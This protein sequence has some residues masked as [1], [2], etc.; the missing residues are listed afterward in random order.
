MY[1]PQAAA[2]QALAL[3]IVLFCF[4]RVCFQACKSM[5]ENN[6][7]LRPLGKMCM[8]QKVA[9]HSW[10]QSVYICR[11]QSN[12]TVLI[13]MCHK[14]RSRNAHVLRCWR[15]RHMQ[16]LR[17]NASECPEQYLYQPNLYPAICGIIPRASC[18]S[19]SGEVVVN[20]RLYCW[21]KTVKGVWWRMS[22]WPLMRKFLKS[23]L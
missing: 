9:V 7:C 13:N 18:E 3:V 11:M 20:N 23:L 8:W 1:S 2:M 14:L 21:L 10:S 15:I 12:L 6:V 17:N 19:L 5:D 22:G 16:C 4:T